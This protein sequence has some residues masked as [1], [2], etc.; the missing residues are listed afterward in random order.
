MKMKNIKLLPF[1][2]LGLYMTSINIVPNMS[3]EIKIIF[4]L[5]IFVISTIIGYRLY[6]QGNL[7]KERIFV[8]FFFILITI[9]LSLYF[10]SK[11]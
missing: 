1:V 6:K 2:L 10:S 11:I 9:F 5:L 4:A 3:F 7:N 8:F